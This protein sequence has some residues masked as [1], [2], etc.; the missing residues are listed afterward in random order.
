VKIVSKKIS[1]IILIMFIKLV[2]ILILNTF[3]KFL[4]ILYLES[5][6]LSVQSFPKTVNIRIE[7][8]AI[9]ILL[10]FTLAFSNS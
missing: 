4:N 1:V 3:I 5:N 10:S 8:I 7:K 6:A 9:I 2:I